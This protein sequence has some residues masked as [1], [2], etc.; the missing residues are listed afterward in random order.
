MTM[1]ITLFISAPDFEDVTA[2]DLLK[3]TTRTTNEELEI[4]ERMFNRQTATWSAKSQPEWRTEKT[5]IVGTDGNLF[6]SIKTNSTPFVFVNVPRKSGRAVFSKNYKPKTRPRKIG[7]GPGAGWVKGG[8]G[9]QFKFTPRE[10]EHRI[11][12][13]RQPKFTKKATKTVIQDFNRLF[14]LSKRRVKAVQ[15]L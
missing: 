5:R 9:K 7:S 1:G 15:I 13:V 10:V 2:L 6:A 12:E 11:A 3:F 14:R 8:V 4:I